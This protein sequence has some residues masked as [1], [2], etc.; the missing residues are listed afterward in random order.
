MRNFSFCATKFW[1]S[2]LE[3]AAV[4]APQ[5]LQT[6][7]KLPAQIFHL[8]VVVN[9]LTSRSQTLAEAG[10]APSALRQM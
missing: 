6:L 9:M 10:R 7:W 1:R 5:L 8:V 4:L 3:P 2:L